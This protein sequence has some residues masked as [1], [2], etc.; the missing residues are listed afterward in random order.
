MKKIVLL[1]I[2]MP[3]FYGCFAQIEEVTTKTEWITLGE[4]KWM[5]IIKAQLQYGNSEKDTTYLLYLKDE[6]TLKNSRDMS[7]HRHF[8]IRFANDGNTLSELKRLLFSFFESENA[9]NKDY[10]KTFRLGSTIVN[11][12]HYRKLTSHTIMFYTKEGYILFT[13]REL[14]KLFGK[15]S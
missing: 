3:L 5:G 13:K 11:V 15:I 6:Q 10:V 7:V 1:S 12:Q 14:G 4:L 8:S 2:L 9:K